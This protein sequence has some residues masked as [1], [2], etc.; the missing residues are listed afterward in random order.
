MKCESEET[1]PTYS[2]DQCESNS[3]CYMR[4]SD[5]KER[6]DWV[7]LRFHAAPFHPS[8]LPPEDHSC[9]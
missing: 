4:L 5:G 3:I 1:W 7:C 8:Q 6:Q 2:S 9:Q